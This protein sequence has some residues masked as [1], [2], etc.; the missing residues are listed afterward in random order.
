MTP[1]D[2]DDFFGNDPFENIVREFFSPGIRR[3]K[4]NTF[5]MGE[6]EDRNIDFIEDNDYVYLIFELQGY[7]EKDVSI[8]ING[9]ELEIKASKKENVCELENIQN[10]L[11]QKLCRGILIKKILPRFVSPKNFKQTFKNGILE[12]KFAKK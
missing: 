7:N 5:I 8:K 9:N 4:S 3:R 2:D 10:Y 1:F 6:E 12:V 11:T